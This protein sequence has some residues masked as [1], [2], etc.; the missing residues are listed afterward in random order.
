MT[1]DEVGQQFLMIVFIPYGC[2]KW[3]LICYGHNKLGE[4]IRSGWHYFW[5]MLLSLPAYVLFVYSFF[6]LQPWR[7]WLLIFSGLLYL[8]SLFTM[9]YMADKTIKQ[10]EANE[11]KVEDLR[12]QRL[13]NAT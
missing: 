10:I 6:Q 5:L 2:L 3:I 4:T 12:R 9:I 8:A 13:E 7:E 11:A 1:R